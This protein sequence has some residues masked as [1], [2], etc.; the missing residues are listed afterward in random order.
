MDTSQIFL[1]FLLLAFASAANILRNEEAVVCDP[2]ED[3][4]S[5]PTNRRCEDE[6]GDGEYNC[7]CDK[8]F[9]TTHTLGHCVLGFK[10]L[11]YD[12]EKELEVLEEKQEHDT[13]WLN[14]TLND[15]LLIPP[16]TT[17]TTTTEFS[18]LTGR[19]FLITGGKADNL[20]G[21]TKV[22]DVADFN[23]PTYGCQK[24]A[25]FPVASTWMPQGGW[26]DDKLII[27][28]P[29][30]DRKCYS[31]SEDGSQWDQLSGT[32]S[33]Q[34]YNGEGVVIKDK[35]GGDDKLWLIGPGTTGDFV[36]SNGTIQPGDY[37]FSG[38]LDKPCMV[39]LETGDVLIMGGYQS[40]KGV[41]QYNP[42]DG[43]VTQ[44]KDM[45][46]SRRGHACATFKSEKHGGR[47][48]VYVAGGLESGSNEKV[49]LL[50]YSV[51]QDWERIDDL[52][53]GTWL[54][55]RAVTNKEGTGVF[56]YWSNE[57]T[58]LTCDSSSCSFSPN[59]KLTN[60]EIS[61]RSEWP[62]II[63]LPDTLANCSPP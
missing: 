31:L 24:I 13:K 12:M 42:V 3:P 27:C 9:Y 39:Q 62:I 57:V 43:T 56:H 21:S 34:R 36:F 29:S 59:Q 25:D 4:S 20:H 28:S 51:T 58:E 2:A 33:A 47:E 50:D 32:L 40:R 1:L 26:V 16:T 53:R 6:D 7:V 18:G 11:V 37:P 46:Y 44:L 54:G 14:E 61:H 60:Q 38:S 35:N 48:V 8:R 19:Y 17:T 55:P 22:T 15:L 63:P 52:P 41:A 30:G 23:N 49:E 45:I 5:C 10:E